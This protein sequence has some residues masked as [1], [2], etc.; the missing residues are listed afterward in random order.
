ML[1][2]QSAVLFILNAVC[3]KCYFLKRKMRQQS[4][5]KLY[6]KHKCNINVTKMVFVPC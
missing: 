1:E 4:L 5:L 3:C 2:W 6:L